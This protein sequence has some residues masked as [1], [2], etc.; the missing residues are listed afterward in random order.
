MRLTKQTHIPCPAGV[1]HGL[2]YAAHR[3]VRATHTGM[4]IAVTCTRYRHIHGEHQIFHAS[5][6]SSLQ[7]VFHKAAIF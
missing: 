3:C 1:C 7:H 5:G 6:F 2:Q 4:H